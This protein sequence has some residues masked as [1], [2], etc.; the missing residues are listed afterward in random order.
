MQ[1]ADENRITSTPSCRPAATDHAN[2]KIAEHI[3][4]VVCTFPSNESLNS[5]AAPTK[6]IPVRARKARNF[7]LSGVTLNI[8]GIRSKAIAHII[9]VKMD[10][11]RRLKV[12]SALVPIM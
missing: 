4:A 1:T 2:P 5:G 9:K 12:P 10:A 3:A 11:L 6:Q 8:D 7:K